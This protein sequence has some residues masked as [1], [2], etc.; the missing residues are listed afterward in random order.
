MKE[1]FSEPNYSPSPIKKACLDIDFRKLIKY[2]CFL[3]LS[4]SYSQKTF[5]MNIETN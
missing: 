2:K 4:T 3:L 5:E 1:N